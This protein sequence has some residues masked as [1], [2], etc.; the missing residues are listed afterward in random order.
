M[1]KH[2]LRFGHD[3]HCSALVINFNNIFSNGHLYS[4][5]QSMNPL[6][7]QI[8]E[9]LTEK[10]G[11]PISVE[12]FEGF[13]DP[14]DDESKMYEAKSGRAKFVTIWKL[15]NGDIELSIDSNKMRDTWIRLVYYDK[16]NSEKKES[17]DLDDL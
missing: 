2:Q 14:K 8:L 3:V 4:A 16:I 1:C 15:K 11:I 17:S 13:V 10:Y 7:S 6:P 5:G 9:P 12:K